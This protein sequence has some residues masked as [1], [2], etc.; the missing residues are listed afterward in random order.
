[1]TILGSSFGDVSF[2]KNFFPK[3]GCALLAIKNMVTS[4]FT[5]SFFS[6]VN[7]E[8]LPYMLSTF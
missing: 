5:L 1:M 4:I 8:I 7:S 3:L 2:L 6:L